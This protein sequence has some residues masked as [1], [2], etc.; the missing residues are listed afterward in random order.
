MVRCFRREAIYVGFPKVLNFG[1]DA[2]WLARRAGQAGDPSLRLK[3]GCAQDDADGNR[4]RASLREAGSRGRLSPHDSFLLCCFLLLP[5]LFPIALFS[6]RGC[7]FFQKKIGGEEGGE[8]YGDYAVH[9]EEG[10]VEAGEIVGL[11]E[12]MFVEKKKHNGE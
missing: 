8:D 10:G 7:L 3:N 1:G 11:D 5:S 6:F 9:G 12:G 2:I 4:V